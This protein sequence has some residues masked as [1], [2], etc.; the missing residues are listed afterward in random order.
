LTSD[1][2]NE[3]PC[4]LMIPQQYDVELMSFYSGNIVVTRY[5]RPEGFNVAADAAGVMALL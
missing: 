4:S 5:Y 3:F 1:F 2:E